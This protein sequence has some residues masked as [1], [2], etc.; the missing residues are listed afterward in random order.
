MKDLPII[1]AAL[2]LFSLH[3]F[4]ALHFDLSGE[5]AY[6]WT[7]SQEWNLGYWHHPPMVAYGV[8]LG[9]MLLGKTAF[10]V[11]FVGIFLHTISSFL[12]ARNNP[13][14]LLGFLLLCTLPG[15]AQ[16][17]MEASPDLYLL[18]FFSFSLWAFQQQRWLL[19]TLFLTGALLSKVAAFLF[20]PLLVPALF[21]YTKNRKYIASSMLASL[22]CTLPWLIWT[23][24]HHAFPFGLFYDIE[25][26]HTVLISLLEI[27]FSMGLILCAPF[28][29]PKTCDQKMLWGFSLFLPLVCLFFVSPSFFG[30]VVGI[31]GAVYLLVRAPKRL[32]STILGCNLFFFAI[33]TINLHIPLL[34]SDVHPAH[35]YSGGVILAGVIDAWGV[36]DVWTSSPFDAAWIRFYSSKRAHTNARLGTESQF[37]LWPKS[38]P[39]SGIFVQEDSRICTLI[40]YI[41]TN[42]QTIASYVDGQTPGT[43]TQTHQWNTTLFQ[44]ESSSGTASSEEN[45]PKMDAD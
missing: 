17:G 18:S 27:L 29:I 21:L 7:W 6:Y 23:I 5:E 1:I 30:V 8:G 34:P 22:V 41:C 28:L 25:N 20:L 42:N 40:G 9:T 2:L 26:P 32:L 12:L 15:L 14:P 31:S 3:M 13:H 36:E 35:R 4:S 24:A 43:F 45:S 11:R 44:K 38:L 10:A 39:E 33:Q 16:V 19:F 37:D